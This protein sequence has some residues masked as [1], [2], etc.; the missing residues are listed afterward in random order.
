[1]EARGR[2]ALASVSPWGEGTGYTHATKRPEISY[3]K[4][5]LTWETYLSYS[6]EIN[7]FDY[8]KVSVEK[9]IRVFILTLP[10]S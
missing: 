7:A 2:S 8:K 10:E 4:T 3:C 1:M 9:E 6:C 5:Y